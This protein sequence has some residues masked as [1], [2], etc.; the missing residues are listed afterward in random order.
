ME[1][2]IIIELKE[3][4]KGYNLGKLKIEVLKNINFKVK[5]GD[6]LA[7][8]GP[9]GSGKTTL[10]NLIGGLDRPDKGKILIEGENLDKFNDNQLAEYRALKAGF[11]FQFF[12]LMPHLTAIENVFLPKM[13]LEDIKKEDK[14]RAKKL[15]LK[16]GLKERE[17]HKPSE[18][19]GGEQQRIAIARALIN[20][21]KILLLDEPT[22]NLDSLNTQDIFELLREIN[23]NDKTTIIIGTHNSEIEKFAQ[24]G[25]KLKEGQIYES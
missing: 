8:K 1:P 18:L 25:L 4:F 19:S 10:L 3:V 12:N 22:G 5:K 15:L 23:Q 11:V 16:V 9:S 13:F 20:E 24:R 21:P 6:F 17:N 14:E 2:D 7:I